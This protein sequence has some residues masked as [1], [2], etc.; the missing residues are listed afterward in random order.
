MHESL[1]SL[2]ALRRMI[3]GLEGRRQG[4]DHTL[5]PTGHGALDASL[6]GGLARGKVHEL[7]GAEED[8]SSACAA[9]AILLALLAGGGGAPLLWLRT[10]AAQRRGGAP[11][12]P[13]LVD[14]G[15]DPVRLLVATMPDDAMLLR[16]AADALRCAALGAIVVECW[17]NPRI[18]DLTASRRLTLA[19]EARGVTALLLRLNAQPGPSA[20]ETRWCVAAAPSTPLPADAPGRSAFDLTLLRRRSGPDGLRWHLEWNRDR[21]C[22]EEAG[23]PA[24][25]GAVVPVPADG[26]AADRAVA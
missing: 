16:A 15:V 22:F 18:L 9:F 17:G 19:A 26:P 11:Y 25:P 3:A 24:L 6:G 1:S 23:G 4:M 13:G 5:F 10:D 14:L 2:A 21:C 8:D 7:F 12:G 20:A